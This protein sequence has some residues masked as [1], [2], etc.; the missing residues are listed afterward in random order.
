[1][2]QIDL[3]YLLQYP[4][5]GYIYEHYKISSLKMAKPETQSPTDSPKNMRFL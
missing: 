5:R 3:T 1:M 4:T 2:S